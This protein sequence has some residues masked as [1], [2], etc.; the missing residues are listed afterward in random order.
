MAGPG[1]GPAVRGVGT[2][3]CLGLGSEL[4]QQQEP[5][6]RLPGAWQRAVP[7]AGTANLLAPARPLQGADWGGLPVPLLAAAFLRALDLQGARPEFKVW[8]PP[9]GRG[10]F[11]HHA[12]EQRSLLAILASVC[13]QW[14]HAVQ[15]IR[16]DCSE[17]Y[18]YVQ[19][20]LTDAEVAK[21]QNIRVN[22]VS[23]LSPAGPLDAVGAERLFAA[24]SGST[25]A[26]QSLRYAGLPQQF[27]PA[28]A[29]HRQLEEVELNGCP[30]R[31]LEGP[32][33]LEPLRQLS[34]LLELRLV[35]TIVDL[36]AVPEGLRCLTIMYP[37]RV[38]LP[39][40]PHAA[41]LDRLLHVLECK[42]EGRRAQPTP[43]VLLLPQQQPGAVQRLLLLLRSGGVGAPTRPCRPAGR[44]PPPACCRV[45]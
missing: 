33:A 31:T 28:L 11:T 17:W 24:L 16:M 12:Y 42:G 39:P 21:L 45:P 10:S 22:R 30:G 44:C 8:F 20:Q 43:P 25:A 4:C 34:R 6:Y 29:P 5:P 27:L 23:T 18:I 36:G 26:S 15:H 1:G 9:S 19:R 3:A 13:Q 35:H 7:A 2:P 14:N 32:V 37:K 40:A 41:L 38:Q